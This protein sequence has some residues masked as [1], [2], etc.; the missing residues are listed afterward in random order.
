MAI[1]NDKDFKATLAGLSIA[2]QLA[3]TLGSPISCLSRLGKGSMLGFSC[4]RPMRASHSEPSTDTTSTG[5][6]LERDL[7]C[8]GAGR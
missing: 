6:S 4:H 1:T 8:A 7:A 3:Q 5:H 2:Q